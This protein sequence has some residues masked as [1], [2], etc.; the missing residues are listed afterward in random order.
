[1]R[2]ALEVLDNVRRTGVETL[3]QPAFP[4]VLV[5]IFVAFWLIQNRIDRNDPK[6]ALAPMH[7]TPDLG[8]VAPTE[9]EEIAR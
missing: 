1:L 7:V 9:M 4:L 5:L 3:R 2:S 6:L 8:F